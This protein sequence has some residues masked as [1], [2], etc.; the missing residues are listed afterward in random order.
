MNYLLNVSAK[1]LENFPPNKFPK[2][3]AETEKYVQTLNFKTIKFNRLSSTTT[4]DQIGNVFF[5]YSASRVGWKIV[6]LFYF[7]FIKL[8]N[9]FLVKFM[10][11]R[12]K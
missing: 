4:L 12:F 10:F 2:I 11:E 6:F 9:S 1:L 8:R 5:L 7:I 3:I